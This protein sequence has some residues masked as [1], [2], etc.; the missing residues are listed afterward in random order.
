MI[1]RP[2]RS[3][4]T[5][6]LF[7]DTTL[8]RSAARAALSRRAAALVDDDPPPRRNRRADEEI[9][10]RGRARGHRKISLQRR[11]IRADPFRA[12]AQASRGGARALRRL[13]DAERAPR[14]RALPHH[15]P[16]GDA[17][18]LGASPARILFGIPGQWHA[19]RNQPPP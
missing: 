18:L 9:R 19:L 12:D 13:L 3:T 15:G 6:T 2:P 5:D 17:H 14:R 10:S 1:R 4:P 8:V 11:A 16:A 7:P